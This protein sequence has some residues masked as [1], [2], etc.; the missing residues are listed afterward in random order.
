[1]TCLSAS[2]SGYLPG[3]PQPSLPSTEKEGIQPGERQSGIGVLPGSVDGLRRPAYPSDAI[4]SRNY[5]TTTSTTVPPRNQSI[6][7][8]N[9]TLPYVRQ[10]YVKISEAMARTLAE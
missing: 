3:G 6:Y 4:I 8:W 10:F 9:Y 1:M 2:L 7:T 5:S